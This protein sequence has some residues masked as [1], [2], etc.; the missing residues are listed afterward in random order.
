[1][2]GLYV[3]SMGPAAGKSALCAAL[4][5][6]LGAGGKKVGYLKPVATGAAGASAGQA[7][8]D[9][10][11]MKGVL[12]LDEPVELLCP[13]SLSDADLS[14]AGGV[15]EPVW[16]K[17]VRE[18][19]GRVSEG[20]DAVLV[21]GVS[22]FEA[23]SE[24]ARVAARIVEALNAKAILIVR[25]EGDLSEDVVATAARGF[26]DRLLGVVF[27]AVPERRM[28]RFKA[29]V[30]CQVEK[31]GIKV[32]GLL[33]EERSLLTV[34]VGDLVEHIGGRV[35]NNG[36][37]SEALVESLMVGALSYDSASYLT[38]RENKAVITRGDRPDIQLVALNTST[39]CLVLTDNIG[40][41]PTI[42]S[43]AQELHV[44]I[45]LV[46]KSTAATAESLDGLLDRAGFHHEKKLERLGELLEQHLDLDA[47]YQAI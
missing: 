46:D 5:R 23:D 40:P 29:T 33:P 10:G 31:N 24:S 35:V 27:N 11:L 37:H 4:G 19:Y 20:K 21:E 9:A 42:L 13:V 32:L 22:C 44:P 1:M 16:L 7:D 41:N 28:E 39:V 3:T 6:E 15:A 26:G 38:L 2:V 43:R 36:E 34:T 30:A 18:A 12:A 45:V 17:D 8:K 47:I 14:A 25:Y